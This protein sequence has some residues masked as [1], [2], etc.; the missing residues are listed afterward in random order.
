M[1]TI[2]SICTC[3]VIAASIVGSSLSIKK[4][5]VA[6]HVMLLTPLKLKKV[7]NSVTWGHTC[8]NLSHNIMHTSSVMSNVHFLSGNYLASCVP[9]REFVGEE[10]CSF[11]ISIIKTRC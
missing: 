8:P 6:V 4:A 2:Q 9:S 7:G 5:K 11:K 10:N 1:L 3:I